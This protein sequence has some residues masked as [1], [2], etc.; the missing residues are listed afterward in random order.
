MQVLTL[1]MNN[2]RSEPS[3][4]FR[5][6]KNINTKIIFLTLTLDWAQVDVDQSI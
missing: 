3:S 5:F 6:N 1:T 2:N 4:I